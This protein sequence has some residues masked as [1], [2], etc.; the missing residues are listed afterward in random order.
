VSEQ[1]EQPTST[2]PKRPIVRSARPDVPDIK[3]SAPVDSPPPPPDRRGRAL[4][5]LAVAVALVIVVVAFIVSSDGDEPTT[6][7]PTGPMYQQV[8]NLCDYVDAAPLIGVL[9]VTGTDNQVPPTGS[10]TDCTVTLSSTM[11]TGTEGS[12]QLLTVSVFLA[13]SQTDAENAFQERLAGAQSQSPA[14]TEVTD[15][16]SD[17]FSLWTPAVPSSENMVGSPDTLT[18]CVLEENLVMTLTYVSNTPDT[19]LD[20]ATIQ[21]ALNEIANGLL[22]R[23]PI[24]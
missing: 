10:T 8:E 23:L 1:T 4:L 12:F 20:T 13:P 21:P 2:T 5:I 3:P 14:P 18:L 15:V 19:P 17:A 7:E 6:H 16:G 22:S 9:G 11:T 24:S